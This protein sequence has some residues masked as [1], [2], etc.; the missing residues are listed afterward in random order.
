MAATHRRRVLIVDN[1]EQNSIALKRLFENREYDTVSA[2]GGQEALRFLPLEGFDLVLL[3]DLLPT[4]AS[5]EILDRIR[6]LPMQ[7][8][9]A[10]LNAGTLPGGTTLQHVP[11]RADCAFS[12]GSPAAV[13][14]SIDECLS[15]DG[16]LAMRGP[17]Q[18]V[19]TRA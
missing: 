2:W 17:A 3:G 11:V 19:A 15:R 6:N 7:P 18:L 8:F 5:E 16:P 4:V 14:E 10:F 12:M 9:V 1:S 13:V